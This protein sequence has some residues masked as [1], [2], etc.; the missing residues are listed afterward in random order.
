M[1]F[2]TTGN[3]IKGTLAPVLASPRGGYLFLQE[4]LLMEQDT[5]PGDIC[6]RPTPLLMRP[7]EGSKTSLSHPD[8]RGNDGGAVFGGLFF[9]CCVTPAAAIGLRAT[10]LRM[11]RMGTGNQEPGTRVSQ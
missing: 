8:W 1:V 10:L 6:P 3:M 9:P 2:L 11:M 4:P 7:D 5:S